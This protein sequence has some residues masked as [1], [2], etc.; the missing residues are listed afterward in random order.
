MRDYRGAEKQEAKLI[1][2]DL[3]PHV[4]HFSP[5]YVCQTFLPSFMGWWQ[6]E[7]VGPNFLNRT[8]YRLYFEQEC[9][10]RSL[11]SL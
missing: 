2:I 6:L 4:R 11:G 3:A 1:L 9:S 7:W 8:I 10:K 5:I